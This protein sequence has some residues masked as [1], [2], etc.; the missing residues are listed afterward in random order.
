M[1]KQLPG[2]AVLL[3]I[4]LVAGLALGGTYALTKDPIAEQALLQAEAARKAALPDADSFESLEISED[5]LVDWANAG[6]K[7]V[8]GK[9]VPLTLESIDAI[10]GATV[11]STA[12][13]DAINAAYEQYKANPSDAAFT[14]EAQGFASPVAIEAT[15]DG[16]TIATLKIGDDRFAETQGLGAR[17]LEDEFQSQFVG[18]E[19]VAGY[20][21]QITVKGYKGP[22]EVT[23]GLDKDLTLT[24]ISV[25]GSDFAETAGLGAKSKDPAFTSQFA[26]K[27]PPVVV[28]KNGGIAGDNTI[29]AITAATIT[30]NAVA[31]G[32]NEVVKF[33][34]RDIMGI[35]DIE[36]P[37]RPTDE[38][39]IFSATQRGFA[40][41][42]YV[43]AAFDADGKITYISIGDD[44]FAE[45]DG[46]G[47]KALE[48]D[49]QYPFIGAQ[50]PLELGDV[51]TLTGAT[52]TKTAIVGAL[53][54][55]YS[56][57]QGVVV[58]KPVQEEVTLPEKPAEGVYSATEQGFAGPVYVEAAFDDEGKVSYLSVGDDSFAETEGFGARALNAEEI[59]PF[60]GAKMPLELGSVDALT[61]AT[62]TKTAI[63]NALNKAYD[64]SQ[65]KAEEAPAVE[66]NPAAA[67]VMPEKPEVTFTAE[68]DGFVS[69]VAV[70]A[71]FDG[72]TISYLSIGDKRFAETEGLGAKALEPE[73]ALALLG[74]QVPLKAED[75][76]ILTGAT[77]TKNAVIAAVNKAYDKAQ[78]AAAAPAQEEA[79]AAEKPEITYTADEQGFGGPV[80]VESAFD[81]DGKITWIAIG[82]DAFAE[83]PGLGANALTPEF[84]AQ[85]IGKQMPIA[86]TDIDAIAGA[87]ITSTAVVNGLNAAYEASQ[88][89]APAVEEPAVEEPAAEEPAEDDPDV[90]DESEVP[91]V[92]YRAL[93]S[94]PSYEGEAITF[95]N[96]IKANATFEDGKIATLSLSEKPVGTDNYAPLPQDEAL[97]AQLIGRAVPIAEEDITVDNIADYTKSAVVLAVNQAY[98]GM[99]SIG[100]IGGADGTTAILVTEN[101]AWYTGES[102]IYFTV[103]QANAAFDGNTL[104]ALNLSKKAVGSD[105]YTLLDNA[106]AYQQ[107]L[108][109][110]MVPLQESDAAVED[111]EY[112]KTAVV[113]AINEA[114]AQSL[115]GQQ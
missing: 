27:K 92:T 23:V 107:A 39:T 70:E 68:A 73:T 21:S 66:E 84:Q 58:E 74:K 53:N 38:S 17:A 64:A 76:D 8:K 43:E 82:D 2:W 19:Q 55:A 51:D 36:M 31:G 22:V 72:D 26:G 108:T 101:A 67:I 102:I 83:T 30:S 13:V 78:G 104:A 86:L 95:F 9:T 65:G 24:G 54:E 112:V 7:T 33:V 4:T 57:S 42:V 91:T 35:A 37:A 60:I 81:A 94:L 62:F 77:F 88:P 45:T 47:A 3:I 97:K 110:K 111:A 16:D 49:S 14:A 41:N 56:A 114:Y 6:L 85:F 113:I 75:V 99:S 52:F 80:H 11:T 69:P 25:G 20:V 59:A 89:A 98:S 5:A 61:G 105:E 44:Q 90:L 32:V 109:G 34:K 46:F 100:I 29:D 63:V 103:I 96:V 18:G 12:V 28:I 10:T 93:G 115:A 71:A 87:T 50:M 106:D 79:P 40:S 48:T 1:K 15:F